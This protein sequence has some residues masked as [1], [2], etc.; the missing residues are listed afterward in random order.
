MSRIERIRH[1]PLHLSIS[2]CVDQWQ[3]AIK[4]LQAKRREE[5]NSCNGGNAGRSRLCS[6]SRFLDGSGKN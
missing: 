3:E 1:S 4:E 5:I 6:A 2:E